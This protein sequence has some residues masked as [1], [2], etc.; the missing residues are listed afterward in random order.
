MNL[1]LSLIVDVIIM[2]DLCLYCLLTLTY[3]FAV[4]KKETE[5]QLAGNE[6]RHVP[7]FVHVLRM[8]YYFIYY[9]LWVVFFLLIIKFILSV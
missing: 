8:F 1:I 4:R 6:C 7:K 9:I 3:E 2:A 5:V